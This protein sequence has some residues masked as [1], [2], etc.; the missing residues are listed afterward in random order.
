MSE[1][2]TITEALVKLKTL[3]SRINKGLA[4]LTVVTAK[5]ASSGNIT[6]FMTEAEFVAKAQSSY[7]S[8]VDLMTL[9]SN[10]KAQIAE[11]NA[12]T[13]VTICG[14]DY[15]VT[16][17]IEKKN[18]IHF[19]ESLIDTLQDRLSIALSQA[20]V[21]DKQAEQRANNYVEIT[22]GGDK[23]N[24]VDE[25]Q[26]LYDTFFNKDR[27]V[28]VDPLKVIDLITERE[29]SVSDFLEEVDTKLVISNSTTF[30][31]I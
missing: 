23:K 4:D 21:Y 22:L 7:Q 24:K 10:I 1:K 28:L 18:S 9:R 6:N 31:E 2:I 30:I 19:E 15:T 5:K 13:I 3:E 16:R 25:A 27:G 12:K 14:I 29:K 20:S 17:A 11:A 8:V 26:E